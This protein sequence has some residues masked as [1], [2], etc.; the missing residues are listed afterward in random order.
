MY[1]IITNLYDYFI[2]FASLSLLL[3]ALFYWIVLSIDKKQQKDF[4]T[5]YR[6]TRNNN[7]RK[8]MTK[9][10]IDSDVSMLSNKQLK[11]NI[12]QFLDN[13]KDILIDNMRDPKVY[14]DPYIERDV[15]SLKKQFNTMKQ[16][17]KGTE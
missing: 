17:I 4:D 5:K 12:L 14:D 6:E 11:I 15:R 9:I 8:Q 1:E 16:A 2:T 10:E 13:Y 3:V 7:E